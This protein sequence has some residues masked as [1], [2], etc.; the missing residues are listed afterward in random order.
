[1]GMTIRELAELMV[2]L[3]C[4]QAM[5]FDGGGSTT[6]TVGDSVVNSPSDAKGE[7]A[8]ANALMVIETRPARELLRQIYILPDT[9]LIMVDQPF[10]LKV[11]AY[12]VYHHLLPLEP[13]D[14]DW[15]FG[16]LPGFAD[17]MAI[18]HIFEPGQGWLTASCDSI[19]DSVP[20][21]ACQMEDW[22]AESDSPVMI[23]LLFERFGLYIN[24]TANA[25]LH[26]IG[27][28]I[29]FSGRL[30]IA[31]YNVLGEKIETLLDQPAISG[32]YKTSW[33]SARMPVGVYFLGL[34][35]STQK[36]PIP[37]WKKTKQF[38]ILPENCN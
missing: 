10:Q 9:P 30:N 18:A 13:C 24:P 2:S 15:Q 20:F 7:R 21:L 19:R 37:G 25:H 23:P 32:F 17:S 4:F 22:A 3:G 34:L 35:L 29:P 38:Y 1:V 36:A 27:C 31:V 14:L 6:L 8:V 12:D 5:N 11:R 16:G 28:T 33:D 26:E